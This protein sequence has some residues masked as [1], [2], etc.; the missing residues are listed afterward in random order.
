MITYFSPL[1][2]YSSRNK[3]VKSPSTPTSS[4][5]KPRPRVVKMKPLKSIRLKYQ[6]KPKKKPEKEDLYKYKTKFSM[7]NILQRSRTGRLN[8]L[9]SIAG[10]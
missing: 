7:R 1:Q 5:V 4:S 2:C 10:L 6:H 3:F 9:S 8:K